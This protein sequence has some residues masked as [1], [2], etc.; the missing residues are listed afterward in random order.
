[1]IFFTSHVGVPTRSLGNPGYIQDDDNGV[2]LSELTRSVTPLYGI[3]YRLR[4]AKTQIP[5][6]QK[7][8]SD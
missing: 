6:N 8:R 1:M 2:N 7:L 3:N 5:N 4:P